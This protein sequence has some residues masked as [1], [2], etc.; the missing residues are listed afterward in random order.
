MK[1]RAWITGGVAAATVLFAGAEAQAAGHANGLGEKGQIIL[2][3][4]RLIPVFSYTYGSVTDTQNNVD[5]TTSRS[6]SGI[7][8]LFGRNL[9]DDESHA[10][11]VNVHTVP[12]IAFDVTVIKQLTIGAGIAFGFGL[13]GT[14][15]DQVVQGGQKTTQES[16][17]PTATAIGIAPR[18]GYIF[19]ISDVFAFWPRFGFA[20]YSVSSSQD[21]NTGPGIA[22]VKA[23]DTLFSLD[24]DPQFTWVPVEHFFINIGPIIN[25]PFAGSRSLSR[26]VGTGT[27]TDS[28]DASVF[29][30]G[31]TAGL[32]TW[33][34][35]F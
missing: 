16:D 14:R 8:L 27:R 34:N 3:A 26:P 9:A 7:S 5:L 33:F 17:A 2:S 6:G 15:K 20:F 28:V 13:G 23:T 4:D 30:I 12:R 19:P 10:V 35:V 1:T 18:I 32:G 29:N 11:P 21:I 24:L 31:L 22:T 25:I